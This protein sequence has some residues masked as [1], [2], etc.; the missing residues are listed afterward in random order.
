MQ[1]KTQSADPEGFQTFWEMEGYKPYKKMLIV[2]TEHY[3]MKNHC[4]SF[5]YNYL[6]QAQKFE[7]EF[8]SPIVIQMPHLRLNPKISF[9][10]TNQLIISL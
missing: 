6:F 9:E 5:D 4:Y 10:Q 7:N 2:T 1:F 8:K 3:Q